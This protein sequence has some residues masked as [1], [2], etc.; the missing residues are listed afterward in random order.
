[1]KTVLPP[2][3]DLNGK[4]A[5]VTGATGELGRVIVRVLAA[6]GADV[7]IHYH[8][9]RTRAEALRKE[10]ES[11]GRKAFVWA[12]DIT[13]EA[14]VL[15]MRDAVRKELG[16][17]DIV[18][19]NAV[20]QYEWTSVLEQAVSDFESQFRSTTLH[21]VLMAKA[22][23]P[24]MIERGHGRI[25]AINTECAMQ[26]T[27]S[28]GAYASAKRGQDGVMRVLARELGPSGITVNQVAPGWMISEKYREAGQ[29][30]QEAYEAGVPLRRRGEDVD[31]AN[32][33]SFLAS[34]LASFISGVYLPVS[35]GNVMPTI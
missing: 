2:K 34:D 31:I 8:S 22:F 35:G 29:E 24:A 9:S 15:A 10:I 17:P 1:M 11:L 33:V 21:N 23:A 19:N 7:A 26:C 20:I 12:A 6:A 13:V 5:I 30:R 32:A 28:Q 16:D 25:I 27:P 18:V 3:I 14:E 4:C